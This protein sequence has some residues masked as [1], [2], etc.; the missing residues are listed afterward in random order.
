MENILF[1]LGGGLELGRLF[2]EAA[3]KSYSN[4]QFNVCK[5]VQHVQKTVNEP[6][7]EKNLVKRIEWTLWKLT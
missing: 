3:V 1:V 5:M 2:S 7:Y 4:G 6:E